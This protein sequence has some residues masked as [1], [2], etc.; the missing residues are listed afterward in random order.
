MVKPAPSRIANPLYVEFAQKCA[1]E[2]DPARKV[3]EFSSGYIDMDNLLKVQ[4]KKILV[5]AC[6]APLYQKALEMSHLNDSCL[7]PVSIFI[8][9]T[10]GCGKSVFR[11]YV[12]HRLLDSA[13]IQNKNIY[14]MFLKADESAGA[15]TT[16]YVICKKLDEANATT[17]VYSPEARDQLCMD[18][19]KWDVE[20]SCVVSLIDVSRGIYKDI[21]VSTRYRWYF[22]SPNTSLIKDKDRLKS[23]CAVDFFMDLWSLAEL[24]YA[25]DVLLLSVSES[26]IE[27]YFYKFGGSARSVLDNPVLA[28]SFLNAALFDISNKKQLQNLLRKSEIELASTASHSIFHVTN[29]GLDFLNPVY[30]WASSPIKQLVAEAALQQNTVELE[31]IMNTPFLGPGT[32]GEMI[33]ALWFERFVLAT[34]SKS[35]DNMMSL[36]E[37]SVTPSLFPSASQLL[38]CLKNFM[39]MKSL[40]V[41]KNSMSTHLQQALKDILQMDTHHAILLRPH[42]FNMMAIDAILITRVEARI[43]VLH[44]QAT[45]AEAHTTHENAAIY[46]NSLACNCTENIFQA[47]VF[48]LPK[49]RFE[50]WSRQLVWG[51]GV[52]TLLPQYAILPGIDNV[53][54]LS[55]KRVSKEPATPAQDDRRLTRSM[56]H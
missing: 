13:K 35:K 7:D 45:I 42:E 53:N 32:K 22:M 40:W 28:Q 19:R 1:V 52:S 23:H 43:F 5:R 38:H 9:G 15:T 31:G 36:I 30:Q 17:L 4:M 20:K 50:N 27:E 25:K 3:L 24:K 26:D 18:V 39:F 6:Y 55:K 16:V 21:A 11:M 2:F 54:A 46:L 14:V 44:L 12:C 49:H 56:T 51:N 10:P 47:L 34:K 29:K 37:F 33:E 48:I 41:S 8:L